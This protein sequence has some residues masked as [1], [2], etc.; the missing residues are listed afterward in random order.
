MRGSV[1]VAFA[2]RGLLERAIL[3][4]MIS[5]KIS[6]HS[7]WHVESQNC[8]LELELAN[9]LHVASISY[10][11]LKHNVGE[12]KVSLYVSIRIV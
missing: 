11:S 9:N 10:C 6:S 7:G 4:Y 8:K 12:E 5:D 2:I 3:P 1:K